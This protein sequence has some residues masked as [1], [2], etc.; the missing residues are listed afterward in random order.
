MSRRTAFRAGFLGVTAVAVVLELVAAFD[1]DG[2]TEPWTEHLIRLPWW[3]L[4]PLSVGFGVWLPWHLVTE[5]RRK[6]RRIEKGQE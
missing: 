5:K 6:E 4:V 3:V 1:G 2:A